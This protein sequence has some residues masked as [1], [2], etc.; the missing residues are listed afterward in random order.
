MIIK[1]CYSVDI[2]STS[3]SIDFFQLLFQIQYGKTGNFY[4]F[5]INNNQDFI[6]Q[7]LTVIS[8][9]GSKFN[10]LTPL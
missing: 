10:F 4:I 6:S 5:G 9:L 1:L 2:H 7:I 8:S 3:E